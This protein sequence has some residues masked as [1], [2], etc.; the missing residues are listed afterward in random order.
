MKK[1]RSVS[2]QFESN[3]VRI[4]I[5]LHP[6][7]LA[8]VEASTRAYLNQYILRYVPELSGVVIAHSNLRF[9]DTVA[10]ISTDTNCVQ[11]DVEVDFIVFCPK[12]G[13]S[14]TGNITLTSKDHIGILVH[15]V[16]N[17]TI[18]NEFVS[19]RLF[20]WDNDRSTW[21]R[22]PTTR[23][24]HSEVLKPASKIK[25]RVLELYSSSDVLVIKGTLK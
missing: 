14:M 5:I 20:K 11:F 1:K 19:D 3:I 2:K 18:P 24:P 25:F 7:E 23:K 8:N 13:L 12:P 4:G 10:N 15:N 9:L 16:F 6:S 21:I 22:T 17:A